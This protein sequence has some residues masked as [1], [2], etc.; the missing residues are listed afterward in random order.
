MVQQCVP[1]LAVQ[2]AFSS[3]VS[4]PRICVILRV[5]TKLQKSFE[6]GIHINP[7]HE[8]AIDLDHV[9][10]IVNPVDDILRFGPHCYKIYI[11]CQANKHCSKSVMQ[12]L[13]FCAD[14]RVETFR[15]QYSR[16]RR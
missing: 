2:L 11:G 5:Y 10:R 16:E 12:N 6:K 3:G 15:D 1:G 13:F 14:D 7:F 8:L 9:L 4:K